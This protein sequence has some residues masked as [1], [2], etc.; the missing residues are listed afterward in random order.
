MPGRAWLGE[1][2][3]IFRF[4]FRPSEPLDPEFPLL[5]VLNQGKFM[6]S[7]DRKRLPCLYNSNEDFPIRKRRS[8]PLCLPFLN[9]IGFAGRVRYC[10]IAGDK[11]RRGPSA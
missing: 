2:C 8:L 4:V 6:R 3:V 5:A 10:T 9:P 11:P 7:I 1:Q